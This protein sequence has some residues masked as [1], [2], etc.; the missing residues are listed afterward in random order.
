MTQR[1]FVKDDAGKG[2]RGADE[3][4]DGSSAQVMVFPERPYGKLYVLS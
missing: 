4:S 3:I 1:S 2:P